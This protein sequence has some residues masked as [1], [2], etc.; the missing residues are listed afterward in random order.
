[1]KYFLL[2]S[3]ITLSLMGVGCLESPYQKNLGRTVFTSDITG[4]QS[5]ETISIVESDI[6]IDSQ[7][8][9]VYPFTFD[10]LYVSDGDRELMRITKTEG[11]VVE[12]GS[13]IPAT[14]PNFK[15]YGV[16]FGAEDLMYVIQLDDNGLPVSEPLTINFDIETNQWTF[17]DGAIQTE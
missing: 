6:Q 2:T 8:V 7:F 4:D 14:V 9:T 10:E 17:A 5:A 13:T 11:V 15:A 1:M 16:Q 3:V 12:D